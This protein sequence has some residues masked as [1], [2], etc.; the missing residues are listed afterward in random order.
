MSHP[1]LDVD[2]IDGPPGPF[3]TSIGEVFARFGMHTQDSGNESYDLHDQLATR[4]WIAVDFY[5]GCLIY[6]FDHREI[7][8]V[9]LDA[10]EGGHDEM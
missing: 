4:G 10:E 5:D 9:D 2:R 3:L 6:D 1:L 7:H 8:V